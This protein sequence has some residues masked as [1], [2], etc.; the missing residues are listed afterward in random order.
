M[1]FDLQFFPDVTP[2]EKS[3]ENYFSETLDLAA[4]ADRMG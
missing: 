3:A 4:E 2:Q 1:Q